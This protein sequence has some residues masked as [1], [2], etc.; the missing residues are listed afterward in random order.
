[1][2]TSL[3][4][5]NTWV[6]GMQCQACMNYILGLFEPT[7]HTLVYSGHYPMGSPDDVVAAEIPT[8][9]QADFKEALRCM[10]VTAYNATAEMCRRAL[11]A[12]C[13][14]QGA[15]KRRKLDDMIDWLEE[16]R[17]ITPRLK[18]IAHKIRLGG[19]RGAH[20]PEDGPRAA[21]EIQDETGPV[22]FI[23]KEHAQAI[24]MFTREFFHHIYVVPAELD[25]YDFSKPKATKLAQG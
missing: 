25:K 22:E 10:F 23:E 15:P 6:A 1:M 2:V 13:L 12:S 19:N 24:I 14:E 17:K 11:E 16:Q 7:A 20:P 3:H 21:G 18:D 4:A 8:H 5:G 9:I